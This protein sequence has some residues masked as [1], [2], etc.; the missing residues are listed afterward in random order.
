MKANHLPLVMVLAL[1][2]AVTGHAERVLEREE[3][4]RLLRELTEQPRKTW[5]VA[6]TIEATHHEYAAAR[7]T[8]P[9][10]IRSEID[11]AVEAYRSEPN[12]RELTE[13]LRKMK[14]NAIDFNVR[15]RL[16]NEYTMTS[17]VV[18]KYDG[19]RFYWEIVVDS[20]QDS[21]RPEAGLAG[22][23]M[24]ERFDPAWNGRRAFAWNGREYTTYSTSGRQAIVDAAGKLPRAV[25][26]PLTAG[27]I[28]WGY[29]TYTYS[30]LSTG[31]VAATEA[32]IAGRTQ[33][34]L[35]MTHADGTSTIAVLD[36]TKDYAVTRAAL[37]SPADEVV[38]YTCSA[39][40]P[41]GY[42]WV[43]SNIASEHR[44]GPTNR[45][46]RSEQ[47]V[48]T[49]GDGVRPEPDEFDVAYGFDTRVEYYSSLAVAPSIY[50]YSNLMDTHDL[51][52]QRL[53][54]VAAQGR[55]PQNCATVALQRVA[56]HFGRSVPGDELARLVDPN[57]QTSLY[58][59]RQWARSADLHCLAVRTDLATLRDL[60]TA[61][62]ILYFPGSRRLVV[63]DRV[64]DRYVWWIDLSSNRFYDRRDVERFGQE[65]SE[66][67][68]LL[69]S[70]RPISGEFTE[71]PDDALEDLLGADGWAC[72]LL[73]QEEDCE[74]CEP[75]D[76]ACPNIF[77][78]YWRRYGCEDAASGTCTE[79]SLIRFQDSPCVTDP[80]S[81]CS[82]T[83]TWEYCSMQACD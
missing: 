32:N 37:R 65:W 36:P 52:A 51:L 14:L 47:W 9:A 76:G 31:A 66:G 59:M 35:S 75:V 26:G 10:V 12:K 42:Y 64:D 72:T 70:D 80:I 67:T 41:I 30:N 34:E 3:T 17:K 62:A 24:T 73:L 77:R 69:L 19:E 74:P 5:I 1:G 15:Y 40:R 11:R 55:Q 27:L 25:H 4:L 6:G 54:Y 23:F 83:G 53:A 46:L 38:N 29:G 60:D 2:P 16:A 33:I 13:P 45:L 68:A 57:G 48:I 81:G 22:N 79:T 8:D 18:V 44:D 43:P 58:D 21:V 82:V 7:T 63:L 28:P 56:S 39:Y 20:R 61:Q 71:I 50:L 49:A 78:Y